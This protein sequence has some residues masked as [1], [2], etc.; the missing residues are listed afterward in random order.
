MWEIVY[1]VRVS[2][3]YWLRK[4]KKKVW[5]MSWDSITERVPS[6]CYKSFSVASLQTAERNNFT[7]LCLLTEDKLIHQIK[8]LIPK[9]VK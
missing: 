6:E 3:V 1:M 2:C 8:I 4:C 9:A 7:M 5:K